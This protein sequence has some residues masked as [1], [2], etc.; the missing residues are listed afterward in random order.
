MPPS[1][2][3]SGGAGGA[4]KPSGW[5]LAVSSFAS[6]GG[7]GG[8]SPGAWVGGFGGLPE[9]V[10]LAGAHLAQRR[11][12]GQGEEQGE[13]GARDHRL[14]DSSQALVKRLVSSGRVSTD[15]TRM[16][17]WLAFSTSS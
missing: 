16:R 11:D 10:L 7:A 9:H 2:S 6:G 17:V 1:L 14:F 13:G 4:P 5:G 15:F 12:P 8:T 3:G